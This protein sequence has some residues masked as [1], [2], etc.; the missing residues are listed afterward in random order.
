MKFRT[1]LVLI[2]SCFV[3]FPA[4]VSAVDQ[5]DKVERQRDKTVLPN[6]RVITPAGRQI[7][8]PGARV[9]V[10]ALS[11]DAALLVTSAGRELIA[12]DPVT[13]KI[14]QNIPLPAGGKGDVVSQEILKPDTSARAS[15][16]GLTFSADG[17]KI[18]LSD[19]NGTIKVF[20]V[21]KEHKISAMGSFS[22]PDANAPRR[23]SEIPAGLMV[24]KDGTKLYVAGNLES[25][26]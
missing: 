22:L 1:L 21:G 11:P 16:T 12:I 5:F 15:Y 9:Q 17:S 10:V 26:A 6:N 23:K 24:S 4:F 8:F 19:V 2:V 18:F 20:A 14:V 13:G 25:F 7:E 3:S